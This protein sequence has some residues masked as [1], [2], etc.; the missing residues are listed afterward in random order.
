[1][2]TKMV[3]SVALIM[4]LMFLVVPAVSARCDG[5]TIT[6]DITCDAPTT[7]YTG[8][9]QNWYV[10]ITVENTNS[11]PI[12]D[13]VVADRF[14]GE[15]GVAERFISHG[16]AIFSLSGRTEKVHLVWD[17]GLLGP[18]ETATLELNVYTDM[19]PGEKQEFTSCGTYT[20]NSGA[21]VKWLDDRGKQGSA[22]TESIII[23]AI[24]ATT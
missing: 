14:G 16:G 9:Y 18:G 2:K 10:T 11:Y 4:S 8:T 12:N 20:M 19:N 17:I 5:V 3:S 1:M 21:V 6:K 23:I 22:V 7:I 15:F 24:P 13:V